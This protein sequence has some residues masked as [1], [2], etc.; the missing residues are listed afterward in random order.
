MKS[1]PPPAF[2][3][4]SIMFCS[5]FTPPSTNAAPVVSLVSIYL[6]KK[7][8]KETKKE[9]KKNIKRY[10]QLVK[11]P[12]PS[13]ERQ[14]SVQQW[15]FLSLGFLPASNLMQSKSHFVIL[16]LFYY[17]YFIIFYHILYILYYVEFGMWKDTVPLLLKI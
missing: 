6:S 16:L 12:V 4:S 17:Y 8:K 3:R 9:I 2:F 13:E 15:S 5:S 7:E 1:S 11:H 14:T 10:Q